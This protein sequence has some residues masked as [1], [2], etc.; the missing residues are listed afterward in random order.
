MSLNWD[1]SR[2]ENWQEK[3]EKHWDLIESLIWK[4]MVVGLNEITESNVKEWWY[5]SAR[6]SIERGYEPT[7][8]LE[9]I[10]LCIGL[11][12]NASVY[13]ASEFDRIIKQRYPERYKRSRK[14]LIK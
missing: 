14:D 10:K 6:C 4:S 8:T 11:R 2:I 3:K 9:Q 5:R 13:T 1:I 7:Y 12:T